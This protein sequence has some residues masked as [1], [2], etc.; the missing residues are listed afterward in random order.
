MDFE[1]DVF[2][3]RLLPYEKILW[4]GKPVRGVV[5]TPW[6]IFL[7]PFIVVWIGSVAIVAVI[8]LS[9]YDDP[10][11]AFI[12][13]MM[14]VVVATVMWGRYWWDAWL[15]GK[16]Q[17]ALTEHRLL[18]C[19]VG[20]FAAFKAVSINRFRE[21]YLIEGKDGRGS[22]RIGNAQKKMRVSVIVFHHIDLEIVPE[23]IGVTD[24]RR[25]FD[26]MQELVAK[27]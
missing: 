22:I 24:A 19:R 14:V 25:V 15:R 10:F 7:L 4:S 13:M 17:Y 16:T 2:S 12:A 8:A 11:T 1:K 26:L 6:D 18:I 27:Y 3:N 21:A 9:S 20:L 5:F 23:L